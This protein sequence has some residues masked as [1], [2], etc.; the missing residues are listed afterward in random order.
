[1]VLA[2]DLDHGLID[3]H[4]DEFAVVGVGDREELVV[5]RHDAV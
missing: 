4:I 1:M 5:H 2:P 3:E